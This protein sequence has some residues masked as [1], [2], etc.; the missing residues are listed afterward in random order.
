[1]AKKAKMT[2]RI[3]SNN[4][5]SRLRVLGSGQLPTA[6]SPEPR[7]CVRGLTLIELLISV[8]ILAS[9]AVI[10]MQALARGAYTL[11]LAH[12]RLRAYAFCASKMADLE[13][14][15]RDANPL[16]THGEFRNGRDQFQWHVETS[17]VS[18]DPPFELV[19]LTVGWQQGRAAYESQVSALRRVVQAAPQ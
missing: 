2:W 15:F 1:M 13:T 17:P 19:T 14:H 4:V 7:A 11:A 18:D 8:A 16:D 10:I 3:G 9:A 12:N 5:R 6:H